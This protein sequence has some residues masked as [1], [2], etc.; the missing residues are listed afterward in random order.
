M[1]NKLRE[2]FEKENKHISEKEFPMF[3]SVKYIHWLENKI[4]KMEE[5]ISKVEEK[6]DVIIKNEILG[7]SSKI[8]SMEEIANFN[9]CALSCAK[10]CKKDGKEHTKG[11]FTV[12]LI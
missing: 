6:F 4:I 10:K 12:K 5:G 7:N 8:M 9:L 3:L 2:I 1:N 11:M